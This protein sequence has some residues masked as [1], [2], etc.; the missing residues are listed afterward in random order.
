VAR[1]FVEEKFQS[2]HFGPWLDA[3]KYVLLLCR[4]PNDIGSIREVIELERTELGF[5]K[6]PSMYFMEIATI[7]LEKYKPTP[8][9]LALL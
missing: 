5:Q 4:F 1:H 8:I 7:L 9:L 2:K 6:L 3:N